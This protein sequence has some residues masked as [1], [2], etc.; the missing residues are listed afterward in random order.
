M[1]P[2]TQTVVIPRSIILHSFVLKRIMDDNP[3][4]LHVLA[5]L[6]AIFHIFFKIQ[7]HWLQ[8]MDP[9]E[10]SLQ[11]AQIMEIEE[12]SL[13][14]ECILE[15]ERHNPVGFFTDWFFGCELES[16]DRRQVGRC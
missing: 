4:S 9:L 11:S 7:M 13:H 5:I 2:L 6:E 15:S 3:M 14:W 10:L 1:A 16:I 8:N 12:R